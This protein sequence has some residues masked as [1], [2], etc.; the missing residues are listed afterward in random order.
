ML[1]SSDQDGHKRS[2]TQDL[3]NLPTIEETKESGYT[4]NTNGRDSK[5]Q[6]HSEEEQKKLM[7]Q[8]KH[9]LKV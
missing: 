9:M 7:K 3:D 2:I 5:S 8:Q 4:Q 1:G 6:H